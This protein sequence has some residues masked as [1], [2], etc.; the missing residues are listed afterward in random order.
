MS[1]PST[2]SGSVWPLD[3]EVVRSV[4]LDAIVD[5][6]ELAQQKE[7]RGKK[8]I[9]LSPEVR[10][11]LEGIENEEADLVLW[12]GDDGRIGLR[13]IIVC[14]AHHQIQLLTA[15]IHAACYEAG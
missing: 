6:A 12:V 9:S 2:S 1:S 3:A 15:D 13:S 5:D 4:L 10:K 8:R 7:Q 14:C 11:V